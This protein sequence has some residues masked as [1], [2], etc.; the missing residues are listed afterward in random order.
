M[1]YEI[2]IKP[3]E[4]KQLEEY[5]GDIKQLTE[6]VNLKIRDFLKERGIKTF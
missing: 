3:R 4:I 2:F 1:R 5:E 6:E